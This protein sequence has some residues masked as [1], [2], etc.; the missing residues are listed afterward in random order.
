LTDF[1]N[2]L[3]L[4]LIFV[5]IIII[6]IAIIVDIHQILCFFYH[7]STVRRITSANKASYYM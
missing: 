6:I 2:L 4:A 3:L 1:K 5:I 7:V